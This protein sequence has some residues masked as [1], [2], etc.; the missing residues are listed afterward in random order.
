V[1]VLCILLDMLVSCFSLS[2][3]YHVYQ[4]WPITFGV[5]IQ[6]ARSL[7]IETAHSRLPPPPK[8]AQLS[9]CVCVCVCL[10]VIEL[11]RDEWT[12]QDEIFRA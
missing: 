6:T 4:I 9:V 10:S 11:L 7:G 1:Y 12:D 8:D 3:F 2:C 5:F